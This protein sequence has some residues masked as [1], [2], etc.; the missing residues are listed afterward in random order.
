[1]KQVSIFSLLATAVC[2]CSLN[3]CDLL[4]SL[5]RNE[6]KNDDDETVAIDW[7]DPDWYSTYF[8]D[9]TDREKAGLRG[10]VK[11][12]HISNYTTYDEYEYDREGRLIK[13]SYVNIDKPEFNHSCIYIYDSKGHC[14]RKEYVG[15]SDDAPDY[16]I[17]EYNNTG[18]YVALEWFMM[19]PEV[20]GA[21]NGIQ[22][23]LSRAT[24]VIEQPFSKVYEDVTYS[25]NA[26]GNLVIR[27]SSY[28]IYQTTGEREDKGSS[29]F[30]IV[31]ENDYPKSLASDKLRFEIVD[32]TWYPN[33]MYKDFIYKEENAYNFDTGWDTHT[34][35]MLDN[36]RYLAV[37][38]FDLE[39]K[40]SISGLV[41]KWM[42]KTYD[43]HF[44]IVK[45]EE[46][47]GDE[48]Y[49]PGAEPSY[50]DTWTEYTYD[51]Y[52]N[53]VTRVEHVV[54]RYTGQESDTNIQRVMEYFD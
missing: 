52:G 12:W 35:K 36:P 41:P 30:T 8:W 7:S 4:D 49:T 10:P 48:D 39:G 28:E 1:M 3:S 40:A 38:T 29:E 18:K 14:T 45:N 19:G 32:I 37:E 33:G 44:D 53:W 43:T 23:D 21:E 25:F 15:S 54:A 24:R 16:T 31:Y 6:Q 50:T 20:S 34:Y 9:R 2:V 17:F 26:D 47:Y 27:Q 13:E 11:K 42:R 51:K 5:N 46:D 22:K